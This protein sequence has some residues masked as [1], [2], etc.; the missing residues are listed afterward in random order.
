MIMSITTGEKQI[1]P[2]Q[3]QYDIFQQI[4]E[5]TNKIKSNMKWNWVKSHQIQPTTT[6]AILNNEAYLT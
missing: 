3:A 5:N 1:S 2:L 4:I 6:D